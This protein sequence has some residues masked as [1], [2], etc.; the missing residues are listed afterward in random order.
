MTCITHKTRTDCLE[1]WITSGLVSTFKHVFTHSVLIEPV[2]TLAI[3]TV[4][5]DSKGMLIAIY[6]SYQNCVSFYQS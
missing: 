2:G 6:Y 5:A 1:N 3:I 4:G